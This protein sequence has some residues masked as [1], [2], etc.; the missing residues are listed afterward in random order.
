MRAKEFIGEAKIKDH[1]NYTLPATYVLPD[2]PNSDAYLQYRM[3]LQLAA[4]GPDFYKADADN[5]W[6]QNMAVLAYSDGEEEI[7]KTAL[8]ANGS[9]AELISTSKSE[10]PKG[11]NKVSPVT[12]K[13]KNKYGV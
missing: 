7:L 8:K 3:G 9:S 4:A 2:L 11:V 5:P 10:E 12:V 6:G 1:S 13:K